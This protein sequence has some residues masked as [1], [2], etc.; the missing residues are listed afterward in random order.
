MSTDLSTSHAQ[1]G[2]HSI[3]IEG[4]FTTQLFDWR[5]NVACFE[6]GKTT[7]GSGMPLEMFAGMKKRAS[8]FGEYLCEKEG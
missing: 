3:F 7:M 1:M 2:L 8:V 5:Q 4:E 6:A